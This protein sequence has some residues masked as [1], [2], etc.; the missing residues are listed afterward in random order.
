MKTA[1]QTNEKI[2][3]KGAANLQRGVETVGG[4]LFLTDQRL[5]FESH[6]F[7]V[8]SGTTEIPLTNIARIV[9]CWTKFLNL[10]PIMPNSLAVQTTDDQEFRLVLFGRSKWKTEIEQQIRG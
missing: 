5:V 2:V 8:H 3:R 10:I 9:P 6:A 4:K 7:N 1:L